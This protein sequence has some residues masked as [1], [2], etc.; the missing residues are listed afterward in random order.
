VWVLIREQL[1][2]PRPDESNVAALIEQL[3][4]DRYSKRAEASRKL[5]ELGPEAIGAM[6][7]A[8]KTAESAEIRQRL[9]SLLTRL[10]V[11][12]KQQSDLLRR[13]RAEAVL[14]RIGTP[15][16]IGLLR[17][18]QADDETSAPPPEQPDR[19]RLR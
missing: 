15:E 2:E 8:L 9:R 4:S 3:D 18:L 12:T 16:A 14:R 5:A 1:G 17:H 19:N 7:A 11:P 6:R 13:R 10:A